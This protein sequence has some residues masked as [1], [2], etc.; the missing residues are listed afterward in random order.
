MGFNLD[1]VQSAL[2]LHAN[3]FDAALNFLLEPKLTAHIP[4]SQHELIEI[5]LVDAS[6]PSGDSSPPISSGSV[7]KN[8]PS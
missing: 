3:N 5:D 4:S 7:K 6:C 2:I 1:A 8:A